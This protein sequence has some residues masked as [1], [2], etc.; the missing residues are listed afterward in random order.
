MLQ[1]LALHAMEILAVQH[2][3]LDIQQQVVKVV[4]VLHFRNLVETVAL[5]EVLYMNVVLLMETVIVK[6][7]LEQ[8]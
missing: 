4:M 8:V 2:Q 5:V 1:Y 7:V 3:H 6:V